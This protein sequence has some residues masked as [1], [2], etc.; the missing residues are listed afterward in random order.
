[1]DDA[2]LKNV[3]VLFV[4]FEDLV[5]DPESQLMN[6]MRFLIGKRDLSGT[7]AERR[8]KEVIAKGANA[9]VT[10]DLKEGTRKFNSNA[11]RY[12]EKQ[13]AYIQEEIKDY[14]HYFGYT[15][16][17]DDKDNFT[18]FFNYKEVDESTKKNLNA[19]K[20]VTEQSIDWVASLNDEELEK[21]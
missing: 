3:P 18:S 8:V 11:H 20:L 14:I 10:Y 12:T 13:K 5:S 7:N 15:S 16:Y 19:Y 9:T 17:D 2:K 1:M 4:R 21:I 6:I